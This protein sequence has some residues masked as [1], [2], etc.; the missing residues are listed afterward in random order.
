MKN[1]IILL[2]FL[3]GFGQVQAQL[4]CNAPM[5]EAKFRRAV[6]GLSVIGQGA[7]FNQAMRS[8]TSSSCLNS[9]QIQRLA[10]LYRDPEMRLD[11]ACFAQSY[12]LDRQNYA[13]LE[14][15]FPSMDMRD[16][17][18]GCIGELAPPPPP[19]PTP[20]GGYN[21]RI[22]CG[23]PAGAHKFMEVKNM[24]T[25]YNNSITRMDVAEQIIPRNCFTT[26][27]IREL[28]EL[29]SNSI[30]RRD[31]LYMAYGSTFDI[32]NYYKMENMFS[33]S[34]MRR[35]FVEWCMAR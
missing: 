35:E 19:P 15:L 17:F 33:N 27:Q 12:T 29:W 10:A 21:G 16:A 7:A 22:G 24:L 30:T 28:A 32:D 2:T 26:A 6:L 3:L 20:I 14:T 4:K 5:E 23:C 25:S 31:F 1:L 8:F 34:I 13:R 11:Y 18:L 9:N